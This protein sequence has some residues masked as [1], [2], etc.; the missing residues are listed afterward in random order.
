MQA[1][2]K[3]RNNNNGGF[4]TEFL[5]IK[6]NTSRN[7]TKFPIIKSTVSSFYK[8]HNFKPSLTKQ[9]SICW[10]FSVNGAV[11]LQAVIATSQILKSLWE[12]GEGR[13][14]GWCIKTQYLIVVQMKEEKSFLFYTK[15]TYLCKRS[16]LH[17]KHQFQ[18]HIIISIIII[19][20]SLTMKPLPYLMI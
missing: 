3:N 12:G 8:E 15:S 1:R 13:G 2:L 20:N 6:Y 4:Y 17:S 9:L 10:S 19:R 5:K 18:Q 7:C 11:V 14:E 16:N